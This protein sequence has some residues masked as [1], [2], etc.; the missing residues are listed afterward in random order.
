M[1]ACLRA[2]LLGGFS[3]YWGDVPL[4]E[5]GSRINKNIELLALL[6]VGGSQPLDNQ[7]LMEALWEG[8]AANPAGALKNAVYSLRRLLEQAAPGVRFIR[9]GGQHY[10]LEPELPVELDTAAFSRLARTALDSGLSGAEK[11]AACRRGLELYTGEFVPALSSRPWARQYSLQLQQQ[12]FALTEEAAGL[13]LDTGSPADAREAYE[14]CGRALLLQPRQE[15]LYAPLFASMQRLEMKSAVRSCYPVV[16]ELFYNQLERPLPRQ[17]R[18]AWRWACD[19]MPT[20]QEDLARIRK[21][22]S[23]IRQQE[24]PAVGPYLCDYQNFR[25]LYPLLSRAARRSGGSLAVGLITL[26]LHGDVSDRKQLDAGMN[27]LAQGIRTTLRREDV[28]CRYGRRQFAVMMILAQYEDFSTVEQRLRQNLALLP[29]GSE[30]GFV[31]E[32]AF[33]PPDPVC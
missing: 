24:Q 28:I 3:V 8:E 30:N 1:S 14:I 15:G 11:L 25:S 18:A 19:G 17:V 33:F 4:V 26:S 16:L 5:P 12:Y 2:R 21:D 29:G 32:T 23:V 20:C 6:L 10:Q 9:T 7:Q 27:W 31:L 22:F 13:L